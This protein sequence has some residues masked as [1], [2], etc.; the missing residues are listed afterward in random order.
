MLCL[1]DASGCKCLLVVA[2]GC[3]Y[4]HIRHSIGSVT[5]ILHMHMNVFVYGLKFDVLSYGCCIWMNVMCT[6]VEIIN[7]VRNLHTYGL[8]SLACFALR[9]F[10]ES[11]TS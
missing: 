5:F 11:V 9:G 3:I 6:H 4:T 7:Y 2:C 8:I 1:V 10:T